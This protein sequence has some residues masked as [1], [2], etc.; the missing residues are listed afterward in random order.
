MAKAKRYW[1]RKHE[2]YVAQVA[3]IGYRTM[4]K[5]IGDERGVVL[6]LTELP[7]RRTKTRAQ[8]DLDEWAAARGLEEI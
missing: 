2:I 1:Y 4:R 7:V 5:P 8:K 3:N 6:N